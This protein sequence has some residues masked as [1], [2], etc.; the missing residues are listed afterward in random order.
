MPRVA[1]RVTSQQ[2][3]SVRLSF[4][5]T[6]GLGA[7]LQR[8]ASALAACFWLAEP[9]LTETRALLVGVSAYDE[10]IGLASLRGPANDVAL[11]RDVLARRGVADIRILA[12]GVESSAIPTRAAILGA[13]GALAAHSAAGDLVMVT[14]SGHGT[15][16]PDDNGEESDG[17]D[18]VFLPA[19]T[20]RSEPGAKAIPNA[21]TDDELGAAILAIR[22]TGADVWFVM[23][24]CHS[25]SGLRAGDLDSAARFVDPALFGLAAPEE[26][27]PDNI[28]SEAEG[29]VPGGLIAFYAARS[30]EVAREVNL[31]PDAAGDGGWYG[32]FSSR[33][34]ARLEDPGALTYRQLFQAV[35]EDMNSGAVPGG[36]RLQTPS[37]EGSMIDAAVFGGSATAGLRQFAVKRDEIA[38]G[39]VHGL[40]EGSLIALVDDAAAAPDTRIALAQVEDAQPT[41]AYLRRVEEDCT[42]VAGALCDAVGPMP[43][44]ARYGRVLSRPLATALKLSAVTDLTSGVP[45]AEWDPL[46]AALADAVAEVNAGDGV[47]VETDPADFVIEVAAQDG[48]LWFGG[49]AALQGLPVGLS[50]APADGV[51]L[52]PL[53]TRM[54]KAEELAAFL[55]SVAE[56]GS[57]LNPAPVDV[58][59]DLTP[60]RLE[61]LDPPGTGSNPIREC[62]RA[63]T[64]ARADGPHPLEDAAEVKQCDA[65][66]LSVRGAV[67]GARDVN[68]IHIDAQFC[69]TA[70]HVHVED[71]AA[72]TRLGES[73]IICSDCP[74]GYS[75]GEER[76]FVL[77]TESAD[78]A[79]QLDLSGLVETCAG[80]GGAPTRGG[81][82]GEAA[83]FLEKLGRRPDT[84]G[85]FGGLSIA[86]VWVT[87]YRWQVLPKELAFRRGTVAAAP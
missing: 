10:S 60:S 27:T 23:D 5:G 1:S 24:S 42:P 30:S 62:S 65:L 86:D 70:S 22:A 81:A 43:A 7:W 57:P 87:R 46:L 36:A 3:N 9:G 40:V 38:A 12:D 25:G 80:D 19:D 18:E 45:L 28:T 50:W 8:F 17:L 41:R 33:L 61:D 59:A 63:L 83:A 78:N 66:D 85:Q 51:A 37:W 53:L 2:L 21:I 56:T 84:R 31:A 26:G 74:G 68:R 35:L 72:A 71:T 34:A 69:V 48:R 52:A 54:A 49:R 44:E 64:H 20:A 79:E 75:A 11:F 15:R 76:L 13:L 32:L 55:T 77:I 14:M 39:R 58:A 29:D 16:Q 82:A 47:Q 73:M 4:R 67:P 6:S